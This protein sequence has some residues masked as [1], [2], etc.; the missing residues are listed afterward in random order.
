MTRKAGM[1]GMHLYLVI[2]FVSCLAK[3]LEGFARKTK[4]HARHTQGEGTTVLW[5]QPSNIASRDLLYG[6]GGKTGQPQGVFTF[7][8]E[9]TGGASPKFIVKDSEARK[10]KVKLG[11]EAGPETTATRLLWVVGYFTDEDYFRSEIVVKGLK[12]L[13]RGQ[14]FV[15]SGG[16]IRGARLE[17]LDEPKTQKVG[18]W[19]W[20]ANVFKGSREFNGLAVMMALLNN[21]DLKAGNNGIYEVGG[22]RQYRVTD[23]G[24]TFGDCDWWQRSKADLNAYRKA[25]FLRK[26]S[27]E[28][29]DFRL[30][31]RPPW[32]FVFALPFYIQRTRVSSIAEGLPIQDVQWIGRL[33]AQL[34]TQQISDAFRAGGFQP[35]EVQGFTEEIQKRIAG[36]RQLD[37]QSTRSAQR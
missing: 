33:L 5:R 36:L 30:P 15:S 4:N 14:Q 18:T 31:T 12:R 29:V 25:K 8:K 7:I 10:W 11:P 26:A 28:D 34:S 27:P 3:P 23:L 22:E 1:A 9:D 17:L 20:Q 37:E 19:G 13:N 32:L 16:R 2:L 35:S 21:W 24:A 6:V